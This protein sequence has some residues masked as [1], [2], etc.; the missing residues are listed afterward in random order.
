MIGNAWDVYDLSTD[1]LQDGLQELL[2][3]QRESPLD[4]TLGSR[5]S[6]ITQELDER[7][8]S[9][10]IMGM[11]SQIAWD[12]KECCNPADTS[13]NEADGERPSSAGFSLPPINPSACLKFGGTSTRFTLTKGSSSSIIKKKVS[14]QSRKPAQPGQPRHNSAPPLLLQGSSSKPSKVAEPP[15]RPAM[16]QRA[17]L[18]PLVPQR[19]RS[20]PAVRASGQSCPS[21]PLNSKSS[22]QRFAHDAE[23]LLT[24]S[25]ILEPK[26]VDHTRAPESTVSV[27]DAPVMTPSHCESM[28]SED[29]RETDVSEAVPGETEDSGNVVLATAGA[30]ESEDSGDIAVPAARP[31]A[32]QDSE[33]SAARA[34]ESEDSGDAA[35]PVG[36]PTE[37]VKS[38]D[39][40]VPAAE[41]HTETQPAE[42]CIDAKECSSLDAATDSLGDGGTPS[43]NSEQDDGFEVVERHSTGPDIGLGSVESQGN[44]LPKTVE[45]SGHPSGSRAQCE[46]SPGVSCAVVSG[47]GVQKPCQQSA[48]K[49]EAMGWKEDAVLAIRRLTEQGIEMWRS[50]QEGNEELP[51]A[52]IR[53]EA[54]SLMWTPQE[55]SSSAIQLSPTKSADQTGLEETSASSAPF[56]VEGENA[57]QAC[58]VREDVQSACCSES[59]TF[60][61]D[62]DGAVVDGT[63]TSPESNACDIDYLALFPS[64]RSIFDSHPRKKASDLEF[65]NEQRQLLQYWCED[66]VNAEESDYPGAEPESPRVARPVTAVIPWNSWHGEM[67]EYGSSMCFKVQRSRPEV[68]SVV[69]Q[70]LEPE[71]W[72]EARTSQWNLLWTWGKPRPN[73]KAL[74]AWQRVNHHPNTVHLTRK[75]LLKKHLMRYSRQRGKVGAAFNIAPL[76]YILPSEYVAFAESFSQHSAESDDINIWIMKKVGMSRGRG[77]ELTTSIEHVTYDS[78]VV[79]QKY[80]PNP[81]LVKGYKFDLRLYV[82]AT[83]FNPLEAY[84][85]RKGFARFASVK[86]STSAAALTN[87]LIHLTNTAV[88]QTTASMPALFSGD[89]G[90]KC[91][92]QELREEL[93]RNG[94]E[95]EPL[96]HHIKDTILKCL[97]CAE[98]GIEHCPSGQ[99]FEVF[100]F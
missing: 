37:S 5:I 2:L 84:I 15:R 34:M 70:A 3:Q 86:Y 46:I 98:D 7:T 78:N 49:A 4:T 35:V 13:P 30:T 14:K 45:V 51:A 85:Y 22:S 99:Y 28:K 61:A 93:M 33:A 26:I 60:P 90:T 8:A 72:V 73:Q 92:L 18:V 38:G 57:Q 87:K 83:S 10:N 66:A 69:C 71:G 53:P 64:I 29:S 89:G 62:A 36:V 16:K 52:A 79:I 27:D 59:S 91:D 81:L 48:L 23:C 31:T 17:G 54:I 21:L 58:G 80:I 32:M 75:D 96:W 43:S 65:I 76:T 11:L 42:P 50:P 94:I 95:W 20:F 77:I 63:E 19:G 68:Y 24:P 39:T 47:W 97:C 55:I 25:K 44:S 40:V 9:A 12:P 82:L 1:Q 56:R 6:I 41:P 74:L 88:Q 67:L 100:W